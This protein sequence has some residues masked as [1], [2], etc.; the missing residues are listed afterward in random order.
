VISGYKKPSRSGTIRMAARGHPLAQALQP[1]QCS[2]G[3]RRG[4]AEELMT[5]PPVFLSL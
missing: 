1:V 5:L 3:A 2:L 4:V